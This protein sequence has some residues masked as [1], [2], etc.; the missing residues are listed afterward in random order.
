[1]LSAW[2]LSRFVL[3]VHF[4]LPTVLQVTDCLNLRMYCIL[5]SINQ[6]FKFSLSSLHNSNLFA[7]NSESSRGSEILIMPGY[8]P[9]K[10]NA[11]NRDLKCWMQQMHFLRAVFLLLLLLVHFMYMHLPLGR[12]FLVPGGLRGCRDSQ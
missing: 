11:H 5:E 3:F 1:M 12:S 10:T 8:S 2:S 9:C 6:T 4:S 7:L